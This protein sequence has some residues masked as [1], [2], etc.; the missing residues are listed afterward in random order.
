MALPVWTDAQV[1]DQLMTR[2]RWY[3]E[4]ITYSFPT[5]ANEFWGI[6]S[7]ARTFQPLNTQQRE[8]ATL[9]MQIWDDLIAPSFEQTSFTGNIK[10][11][12][13]RTDTDYAHSYYPSNG[14]VWFNATDSGLFAPQIGRYAFE[15]FVHEIGHALGLDHMGNYNGAG[16]NQASSFQ[17]SSVYSIMS[18][19][20]PEH[21]VGEGQ[22]AWADWVGADRQLY[23]PQTPML[24]DVMAI[25][26]L[27]GADLTTRTGDTIYGFHSNVSGALAAIYDFTKNANPILTIYDAGGIDT[28]DLSGWLTP[29]TIDLGEGKFSSCNDMTSNIAIAYGCLIENAIGGAAADRITGNDIDNRLCGMGG[30]DTLIGGD[31]FDWAVYRGSYSNYVVKSEAGSIAVSDKNIGR[32]GVDHLSGI[33]RV[34]FEDLNLA[35]DLSGVAGQGYR[36]YKAAFDRMPDVEGLGYW[37][38]EMDAGK[39]LAKV[40]AS[41][42]QSPEF[43]A[44]YGAQSSDTHFIDLL[45]Q[46]VLH[47]APDQSGYDYWL[48]DLAAG[49][50]RA[51]VLALFSESPEN[52]KQTEVLIANGIAYEPWS[53]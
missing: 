41:F 53:V 43:L 23:S 27:Y 12:L 36:L 3:S 22:V 50:P 1:L 40:A 11:G 24:N 5:M 14:S 6:G 18:Y 16:D 42:I 45:Y 47:R 9:S 31:G 13:S 8:M 37:I 15:T 19:F 30:D 33:E 51:S 29:S 34:A 39:S 2:Y 7:E 28:L 32:D 20:G 46:H 35:F 4:V 25:Q 10:F 21:R 48:S 17:D 49:Q 38:S 26:Y 52:L 44:M